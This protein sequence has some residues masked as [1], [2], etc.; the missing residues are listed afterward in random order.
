LA[1]WRIL[2]GALAHW[3]IGIEQRGTRAAP[4]AAATA[5]A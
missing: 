1:H 4:L 5:S 2:I 3:R